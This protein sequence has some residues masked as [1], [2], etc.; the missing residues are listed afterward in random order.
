M[1]AIQNIY[2]TTPC[3]QR[4][5]DTLPCSCMAGEKKTETSGTI[6]RF[7][8]HLDQLNLSTYNHM[9][10]QTK[11]CRMTWVYRHCC[12][13]NPGNPVAEP[14]CNSFGSAAACDNF[15]KHQQMVFQSLKTKLSWTQ[16]KDSPVI[17][18]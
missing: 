13:I 1:N 16:S 14:A 11:P 7:T 3:L 9:Q 2:Q 8:I 6:D 10:N 18:C 15:A 12:R 4:V 17:C 5:G